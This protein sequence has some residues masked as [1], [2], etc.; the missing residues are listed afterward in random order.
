MADYIRVPIG[1]S[2]MRQPGLGVSPGAGV[3]GVGN[4]LRHRR[5]LFFQLTRLRIIVGDLR[6]QVDGAERGQ[7]YAAQN[8]CC[9]ENE[10]ILKPR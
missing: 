2:G 9:N 10:D 5:Q 6:S 4:A 7:N 1:E 8:G 3:L